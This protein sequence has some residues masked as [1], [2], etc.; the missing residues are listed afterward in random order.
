[1]NSYNAALFDLDGTLVDNYCA[2]HS[3]LGES[4]EKFSLP[5][6]S[7][8]EV[9][10]TVGGSIL[11]TAGRILK[12]NGNDEALAQP[13]CEHY[14]KI[15]PS[16]MFDGLRL[17]PFALEILKSLKSHGMKIACFTN[18]QQEGADAILEHLGIRDILD[19]VV[20][21]SLNSPRK[22]EP[23]FTAKALGILG[24]EAVSTIGIGDSL[25]D[26][27]AARALDV[28]SALVATGADSI[29]YLK[30]ECPEC[31]GVYGNLGELSLD[32]F[33]VAL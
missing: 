5:A 2:I 33:G 16:K 14:L 15:F 3:A 29:E 21:T 4:F 11:I 27:R 12:A 18:K 10:R 32:V 8:D 31:V 1:M 7:Y 26:Y 28:A 13:I 24:V 23:E 19:A 25:F 30:K 20:G 22:P 17:L 6:P 9:F